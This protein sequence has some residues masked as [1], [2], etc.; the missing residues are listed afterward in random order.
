MLQTKYAI[1]IET[2]T[3]K[4]IWNTFING[5]GTS[6]YFAKTA[7][8][9]FASLLLHLQYKQMLHSCST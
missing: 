3:C 6:E 4:S 1:F 7:T 9:D 5:I 8:S 2:T